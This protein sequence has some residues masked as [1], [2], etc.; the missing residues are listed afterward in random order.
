MAGVGWEVSR[1]PQTSKSIQF[2]AQSA[3]AN[4]FRLKWP[5]TLE[6]RLE[7]VAQEKANRGANT[8][9]LTDQF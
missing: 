5:H 2:L 3:E 6:V 9:D 7:G 8:C 1:G 4:H